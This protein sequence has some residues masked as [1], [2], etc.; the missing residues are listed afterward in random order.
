[1]VIVGA[2]AA[3][4]AAAR[5][6]AAAGRRFTLVE[7]S[8]RV[9][10]RCVT[11]TS[12]FGVPFDLG[13]H[14]IY[15]PD[16]NPVAKLASRTG[17]DIYPAP[18]AQRL[19]IGRRNARDGEFE[20]FLAALVRTNRA[21]AEAARKGDIAAAQAIPKE[22]GD[23]RPT[24]E[25]VLGPYC[26][27]KDLAEIS[28]V[29]QSRSSERDTSAFCRQGFGALLAKLAEGVPVQLGAPV[30]DIDMS[31]RSGRIEVKTSKGTIAGRHVIVTASTNVL[32]SGKIKF[33]PALPKRQLDALDRLRLG[34][35]DHI[36]LELPGNPLGLQRDDLVLEKATGVQH[37]GA[38]GQ[39]VG[40]AAGDDRGRRPL[41]S[42]PVGQG[43]SRDDRLS[44]STGL[45]A[46]TAPTCARRC[47]ARVRRAGT[48]SPSRSARSRRRRPDRRARARS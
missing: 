36:A 39:R 43:R 18:T 3:G 15:V 26:S 29:D 6:M 44:P 10:G 16:L 17:L 34:S 5:R 25:F 47:S 8:E 9:G 7:A 28:V 27:G 31:A 12:S 45:S 2:G 4:I 42:R 1:M 21:F 46:S 35:L 37:R 32:L 24:I 11:D 19:R 23:W 48:P 38:A 13:A 22:V 20:E 14:W 33:E 40:H 41:R 30:S